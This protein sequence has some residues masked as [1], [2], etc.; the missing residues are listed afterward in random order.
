M[1]FT[2]F[3]FDYYSLLST[4]SFQSIEEKLLEWI[5]EFSRVDSLFK[6][7]S[8]LRKQWFKSHQDSLHLFV[9]DQK[10]SFCKW[11]NSQRSQDK[12]LILTKIFFNYFS[13]IK[14]KISSWFSNKKSSHSSSIWTKIYFNDFLSVENEEKIFSDYWQLHSKSILRKK[15][16]LE[17][18]SMINSNISQCRK[19]ENII[20]KSIYSHRNSFHQWIISWEKSLKFLLEGKIT[21]QKDKFPRKIRLNDFPSLIEINFNIFLQDRN[22]CWKWIGFRR[23]S[24]PSLL[25]IETNLFDWFNKTMITLDDEQFWSTLHSSVLFLEKQIVFTWSN[26]NQ[27]TF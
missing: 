2:Q 20:E 13:R 25:P 11:F 23:I 14:R 7:M 19:Q 16:R 8:L 4:N 18:Y 21:S 12:S 3:L 24:F 17:Y 5:N 10:M 1:I 22:W 15:I 26:K 6:R 27:M 9:F